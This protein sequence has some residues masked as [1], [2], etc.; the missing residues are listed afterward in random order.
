MSETEERSIVTLRASYTLQFAKGTGSSAT[1]G[2]AII[3]SGQPNLRTLTNLSFDQRHKLAAT[4][5]YRFGWG[6]DYNGPTT[7]RETK[8]GKQK[9]TKILEGFGV[10]LNFS[11]GSGMPYSRSSKPYSIYVSG[12]KS[13]LSGTI[14]GSNMP[15]IFQCDLRVNKSF[16]LS[17]KKDDKGETIKRGFLDVY[18]EVLNLFNFKNVIYVY[19]YTGNA[20]DDGYLTATEYQQQINS[21]VSVAS[22]KDYYRMRMSDPYNYTRPTRVVLGVSF[23]F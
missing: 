12:T 20:D 15:W 1:S 22:Y 13:Q 11:A 18:L 8:D 23:S 7:H 2:L 9:E 10:N 16:M 3:Q 5:D 17:L 4:I 6:G 19:E 21:Q 14:N